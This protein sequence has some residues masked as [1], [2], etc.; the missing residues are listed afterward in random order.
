MSADPADQG[1]LAILRELLLRD[2]DSD[3][4]A[5][6]AAISEAA[7]VPAEYADIV[8]Q[9]LERNRE[10]GLVRRDSGGRWYLTAEGIALARAGSE[11]EAMVPLPRGSEER[12]PPR[13][14]GREPCNAGHSRQSSHSEERPQRP[15]E[16]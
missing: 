12:P 10:R 9:R 5:T 6:A 1:L 8:E 2:G 11:R 4:E 13:S 7:G 3:M 14:R 15:G 16:D